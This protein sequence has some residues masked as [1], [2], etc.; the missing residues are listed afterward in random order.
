MD[1]LYCTLADCCPPADCACTNTEPPA[2]VTVYV[3]KSTPVVLVS[4]KNVAKADVPLCT[5]FALATSYSPL[6]ESVVVMNISAD[7]YVVALKLMMVVADDVKLVDAVSVVNTPPVPAAVLSNPTMA[8]I[9]A[10]E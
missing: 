10:P 8:N 5:T 2:N 4:P 6:E 7:L 1:S 3:A 9:L